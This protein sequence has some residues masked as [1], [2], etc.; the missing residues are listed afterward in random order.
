MKLSDC[1]FAF[2]IAD[3]SDEDC[4]SYVAI[5]P[6]ELWDNDHCLFDDEDEE[7]EEELNKIG[8][9][10]LSDSIYDFNDHP[11]PLARLAL[12]KAGAVEKQEILD[13]NFEEVEDV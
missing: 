2:H 7:L 1:Y 10:Y 3:K 4:V 6:K 12:I 9:Q 8:F 5:S 11:L 13:Y